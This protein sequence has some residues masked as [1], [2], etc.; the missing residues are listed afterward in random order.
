ME[1]MSLK[2]AKLL[3]G[4]VIVMAMTTVAMKWELNM[5]SQ[6]NKNNAEA[7]KQALFDFAAQREEQLNREEE[8][9]R[10][11]GAVDPNMMA[12]G[13]MPPGTP[14]IMPAG[15]MPPN[16]TPNMASDPNMMT[17][18]VNNP[19]VNSAG[20]IVPGTA[21]NDVVQSAPSTMINPP[22]PDNTSVI[23]PNQS[24]NIT[25]DTP[26]PN[27]TP[28]NSNNTRNSSSAKSNSGSKTAIEF[29]DPPQNNPSTPQN[30]SSSTNTSAASSSTNATAA[31]SKTT[32]QK[33]D[34]VQTTQNTTTNKTSTGSTTSA[35]D[36]QAQQIEAMLKSKHP[37]ERRK[38]LEMQKYYNKSN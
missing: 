7:I 34:Q 4:F 22:A 32:E 23:T 20:M 14:G 17:P 15:T 24:T 27:M 26:T 37:R 8:M 18:A 33:Q 1:K 16:A 2:Y 6:K 29:I 10:N 38:A 3:L 30:S 28:I 21:P 5:I 9:R 12:P 31:T 35:K 36:L 13:A 19:T 25:P 11:G